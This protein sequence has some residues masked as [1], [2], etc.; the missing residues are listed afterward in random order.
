MLRVGLWAIRPYLTGS[1][2][3]MASMLWRSP[4]GL[5]LL[6]R[7][8]RRRRCSLWV[9][10]LA[11][12]TPSSSGC[13]ACSVS[14]STSLHLWV[15]PW[16]CHFRRWRGLD[17][18]HVPPIWI[19]VTF[20]H[21]PWSKTRTRWWRWLCRLCSALWPSAMLCGLAYAPIPGTPLPYACH[22]R[23]A[24]DQL[25]IEMLACRVSPGVCFSLRSGMGVTPGGTRLYL[26]SSP[27]HYGRVLLLT[28]TV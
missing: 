8:C 7:Q 18:G 9:D 10:L 24:G 6:V 28:L 25:T 19:R 21:Q 15:H 26:V 12:L 4:S 1:L 20:D 23:G 17:E 14:C 16:R 11:N 22:V 5:I 2:C 13:R 3:G 27:C